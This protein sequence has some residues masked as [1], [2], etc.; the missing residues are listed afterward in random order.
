MVV[1]NSDNVPSLPEDAS[2]LE[3]QQ[4]PL[5]SSHNYL[6]DC[7]QASLEATDTDASDRKKAPLKTSNSRHPDNLD[8]RELAAHMSL[9][10]GILGVCLVFLWF[11]L[12]R[13]IPMVLVAAVIVFLLNLILR[14]LARLVSLVRLSSSATPARTTNPANTTNLARAANPARTASSTNPTTP[15]SQLEKPRKVFSTLGMLLLVLLSLLVGVSTLVYGI[16]DDM[17]FFNV[18]SPE[19]R[20]FLQDNPKFVAIEFTASNG[21]TYHGMMY[22]PSSEPAPLVIYFGGNGECSYSAM[23]GREELD[24]WPYYAGYNM[25]CVDYEGYGLNA[26]NPHYLNM[27]AEALAIF[28]YAITLPS[29]DPA[30]IVAMGYSLGTGCAV[31]LAAERPVAGLVLVAPYANGHDIYNNMLPIFVGP[32]EALVKQKLPSDEYAG[33]VTCPVLVIASHADEAVPFASSMLLAG[34]FAGPVEVL[35]LDDAS[36]NNIFQVEKSL[37]SLQSFLTEVKAK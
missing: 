1:A 29:V 36:H 18:D 35:E 28:D 34:L 27:Y 30:H 7:Q 11:N 31:Y 19:S 4:I 8:Y 33:L 21:K 13:L 6:T 2:H 37:T 10:A 16:Q 14:G 5:G 32:G 24:R 26:G 9:C 3:Q 15:T 12:G 22:Q 17:L 20:E 23:R 25:L